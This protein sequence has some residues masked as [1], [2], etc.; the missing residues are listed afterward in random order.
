MSYEEEKA[1]MI[2]GELYY[3]FNPGLVRDRQNCHAKV[4]RYNNAGD[5]SRRKRVEMWKELVLPV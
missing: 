2:R 5:I 4:Q 3:A 1:K